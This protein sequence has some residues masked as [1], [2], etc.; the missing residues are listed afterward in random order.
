[1]DL[2]FAQAGFDLLWA[3][4][5]DPFAVQTYCKNIGEHAVAGDVLEVLIP[6]VSPDVLVGGP[7]CQGFSVIGQMRED[8]PRSRHVLHFLDM[9]AQLRPGTFVM[10]NVKALAVNPR[11]AP[12]RAQL[13]ERAEELG[14][15]TRLVVLNAADYGV[16]QARERMFLLGST[17]GEAPAIPAPTTAGRRPTVREALALLPRYGTPGNDSMTRARVVPT[18]DPVMRPTAHTGSLLFNGS[19]RPLH[20]DRPAKTIPASMGGNATPIIDQDELDHGHEPWVVEYHRDLRAG[21][22]PVS[23]APSRL[24]RIT[25]EEAAVLQGFPVGFEFE[26]QRVAQYRQVGNAVPPPLARAVAESV[27]ASIESTAAVFA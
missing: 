17:T 14:Y 20:L 2:G 15:A 26:G 5:V 12:L 9:V 1:M 4:D 23:E 25:V 27:R 18:R 11:W 19:G 10:E 6:D 13:V 24:R 8:D 22:P 7:P 21:R 3:N 16:P